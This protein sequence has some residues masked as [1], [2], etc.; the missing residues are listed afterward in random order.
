MDIKSIFSSLLKPFKDQLK[1]SINWLELAQSI[2]WVF[3]TLK[4]KEVNDRLDR[5]IKGKALF[6]AVDGLVIRGWLN[7]AYKW[8]TR[9]VDQAKNPGR[10]RGDMSDD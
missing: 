9:V 2:L 10:G 6:E 4:M 3:D 1:V 7:D 5:I 8:A